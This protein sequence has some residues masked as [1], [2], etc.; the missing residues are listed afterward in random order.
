MV[1]IMN[2]QRD[3]FDDLGHVSRSQGTPPHLVFDIEK[4]RRLRD[5]GIERVE[6]PTFSET[7]AEVV[8]GLDGMHVTGEDIRR[9]CT[10]RGVT[11]HHSNAW[12]GV[13]S[14]LVRMGQLRATGEY[15]QMAD[16]RSHARETKVYEV[17]DWQF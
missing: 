17:T 5:E 4:S 7:V 10:D 14:G 8:R 6:K 2:D 1:L 12:G 13:I 3:M 9:I 16:T 15:R 11:P